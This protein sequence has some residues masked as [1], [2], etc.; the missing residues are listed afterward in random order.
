MKLNLDLRAE[1]LRRSIV[2]LDWQEYLLLIS[3]MLFVLLVGAGLFAVVPSGARTAGPR[4]YVICGSSI[5]LW[6]Y[7]A[8]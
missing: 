7:P 4:L 6:S 5:G 2:S 1:E 8:A 3:S